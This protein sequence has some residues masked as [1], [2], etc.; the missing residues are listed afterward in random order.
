[1]FL[2]VW[3]VFIIVVFMKNKFFLSVFLFVVVLA[4]FNACRQ[5]REST[6]LLME[7]FPNARVEVIDYEGRNLRYMNLHRH[8]SLPTLFFLHGSP[9]SMSVYNVYYQDTVLAQWANIIAADRPGY[10]FSDLGRSERSVKK[11]ADKMWKILEHEGFPEPLYIIGSSY[12]GTVAAKMAMLKPDMVDGMVLVSASLAPGKETTYDISYLIDHP[13]FRWLLPG[14]VRVANDEKLSHYD[15]L[16]E[17]LPY[18]E[19]IVAPVVL[20]QGT[21]DRLIFPENALFAQRKLINSSFVDY[22]PMDGEGHF[23]QIKYKDFILERLQD[24]L[25]HNLKQEHHTLEMIGN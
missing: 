6:Q 25:Q 4:G 20:I 23:L 19:S 7:R 24:L 13:P 3:Q 9:S 18:W 17:M 10:G 2:F 16:T 11:Q 14:I 21:A 1:M 12:G 15:A 5:S 8:D 22:Y